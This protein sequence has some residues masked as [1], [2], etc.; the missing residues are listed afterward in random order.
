MR[1]Q[2]VDGTC[3]A[4][5]MGIAV[6]LSTML[7]NERCTRRAL[8]TKHPRRTNVG[9]DRLAKQHRRELI[10][11]ASCRS[12][13]RPRLDAAASGRNAESLQ[14]AAVLRNEREHASAPMVHHVSTDCRVV[15]G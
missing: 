11:H 13:P 1:V 8:G 4:A 7:S 5:A 2:F 3:G 12:P 6:S 15:A 14:N 10:A 9:E